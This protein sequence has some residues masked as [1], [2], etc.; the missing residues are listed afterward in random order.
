MSRPRKLGEILAEERA[1][2]A[3]KLAEKA[4]KAVRK[5]PPAPATASEEVKAAQ[6]SSALRKSRQKLEKEAA[7]TPAEPSR[8]SVEKDEA[9]Q[10]EAGAAFE[11]AYEPPCYSF[12]TGD[13]PL[14]ELA[15]RELCRRKMLPF[16]LRFRPQYIAGW[17]HADIC[18]RVERFV[19]RVERKESPRLL[20]MAPPR[21]GKSE[22]L[23]RNTPPWILGKHPEW[24]L[25]AAS[26]TASL[27]MSFSRYVRDVLRDAAYAAVFPDT[28]LDPSSQSIESWNT[29]KGGGYLAA[30]QGGAITGRGANVFLVDDIVKDAEAAQS[31]T[32]R[33]NTWDWWNSTAYTRLAPGGGVLA[34]MTNWHADDW[35]GRIQET[36]LLGGEVYEV[37]KYPAINET[38]DE[39]ILPDDTI[40]E[41]PPGCPVPRGARLTRKHNTAIHPE[42]YTTEAMLRIKQNLVMSG[43]KRVW[44]ALYQQ[45]PVPDEGN[46]FSKDFFRYYSSPPPRSEL[47]VYQAWDFAISEGKESD[48]TVGVTIGVDSRDSIYVLDVRRFK[49]S[50]GILLVETMVDYALEWDVECLGVEDGQIWKAVES[51]F[52]KVCDEKRCWPAYEPLKPLTDKMVRASPLRG[53]MQAGKVY[54][55]E[56]A[57]WFKDLYK[58]FLHFP[59]GKHDDCHTYGTLIDSPTG[60]RLMGELRDGDEVFTY[61]GSD[62]LVGMV[63]EHHCTGS[64]PVLEVSFSDGTVVEM[65]AG[66]PV[67]TDR[68]YVYAGNLTT[69]DRIVRRIPCTSSDTGSSGSR[70]A[71]VITSQ[72]PCLQTGDE[73][74]CTGTRSNGRSLSSLKVGTFIMLTGTRTTTRLRTL[75]ACLLSIMRRSIARIA[76]PSERARNNLRTWKRFDRWRMQRS[77][78]NT[79][80]SENCV[81]DK[82]EPAFAQLVERFSNSQAQRSTEPCTAQI[83]AGTRLTT[84]SQTLITRL[85]KLANIVVSRLPLG[86]TGLATSCS[87]LNPVATSTG[88]TSEESCV[89]AGGAGRVTSL[90]KATPLAIAARAANRVPTSTDGSALRAGEK[91]Y[92]A[93]RMGM[94]SAIE[95]VLTS[96]DDSRIVRTSMLDT[97]RGFVKVVSIREI[98]FHLTYNFEVARTHNY[99]VHGGIV[100]HNCIDAT[101]WAVRLTLS[102][103]APKPKD[104]EPRLKSWKDKLKLHGTGASHMA[105]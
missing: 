74:G 48:Y 35:A 83:S 25:I 15:S 60:Q 8:R 43:Q 5:A 69:S 9:T 72:Q 79:S 41:I 2:E 19:E 65:T 37:V 82:S 38:G 58:E 100:V 54:F 3:K 12:D 22:I 103:A 85:K 59:A 105:A 76:E 86:A 64:K 45:N 93:S 78:A 104:T 75:S 36:M 50:D 17:V 88:T 47:Y 20:L 77:G 42:R 52:Q 71:E 73:P 84:S 62:V 16:I 68:G 7:Q 13:D 4:Q 66:H 27:T 51:Q 40:V 23:S 39:Y 87:A 6:R 94:F 81:A 95:S 67:L 21:S 32:Q 63:A 92:P 57:P 53:R 31:I 80:V 24:E 55:D 98:G 26:H 11:I 91:L 90:E 33:D 28:V 49:T 34:L 99:L 18:R 1:A 97:N 102:R 56:K 29:T 14:A 96:S 30:G 46:Y 44:D 89:S 61:D 101:A 70:K 10:R